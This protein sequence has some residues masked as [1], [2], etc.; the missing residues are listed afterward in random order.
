MSRHY[1]FT[2]HNG[3]LEI[4]GEDRNGTLGLKAVFLLPIIPVTWKIS[5]ASSHAITGKEKSTGGWNTWKCVGL[6]HSQPCPSP[7]SSPRVPSRLPRGQH[8]IL[9]SWRLGSTP[10]IESV[11]SFLL[12]FLPVGPSPSRLHHLVLSRVAM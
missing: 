9:C 1:F 2:D 11:G 12:V 3:D 7:S 6:G 8:T 5:G 10:C 4:W